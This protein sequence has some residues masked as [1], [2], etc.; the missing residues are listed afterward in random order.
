MGGLSNYVNHVFPNLVVITEMSLQKQIVL[1]A[2]LAV[3][4]LA[5]VRS[6]VGDDYSD[7]ICTPVMN[8]STNTSGVPLPSFPQQ[9]SV[10]I[11]ASITSRNRSA[12]IVEYYDGVG[13][14]GRI[15]GYFAE[16]PQSG[17]PERFTFIGDYKSDQ[18]FR[19]VYPDSE[20]VSC[21]VVALEN[22]RYINFT[23]HEFPGPNGT[24]QIGS[25]NDLLRFGGHLKDQ[26]VYVGQEYARGVLTDRWQYCYLSENRSYV[27]DYYFAVEGWRLPQN[28]SRTPILATVYGR[29]L[30]ENGSY[31]IVNHTY[32]FTAFDPSSLGDDMFAVPE[33]VVCRNRKNLKPLP[34]SSTTDVKYISSISE[35]TNKTNGHSSYS[36]FFYDRPANLV[37]YDFNF[38]DQTN[39]KSIARRVSVIHD[40]MQGVQ[41][42]INRD[43]GTCNVTSLN[44][45]RHSFDGVVDDQGNYALASLLHILSPYNDSASAYVYEGPSTVRGIAAEAWLAFI[46]VANTSYPNVT[47][48]NLT[49][50]MYFSR[51]GWFVNGQSSTMQI[52]LRLR[53]RGTA[54]LNDT[55]VRQFD[56]TSDIF[57]VDVQEP[58]FEVF[59]AFVCFPPDQTKEVM[60]T[61]PVSPTANTLSLLRSNIRAA[62]SKFTGAPG[63]Q[64]GNI[65]V[66][67][68]FKQSEIKAMHF[69]STCIHWGMSGVV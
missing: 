51:D 66:R 26:E 45:G 18:G 5:A 37:R 59:D 44:V 53:I 1:A 17:P 20:S 46:P 67:W 54:I 21:D 10:Q 32:T 15:E 56:Y 14:R 3:V 33:G 16:S 62:L 24:I 6:H 25:A 47:V 61:L 36:L 58:P 41:Y 64:F 35:F 13:Q 50:L 55:V 11:E 52:L 2:F 22:D 31:Y 30:D 4:S 57:N 63:S 28:A 48:E 29:N 69:S 12:R 40:F 27:I 68:P 43:N 34:P 49:N 39:P 38:R 9:F 8:G 60:F 42:Q 65:E 19:I 7:N 23:F